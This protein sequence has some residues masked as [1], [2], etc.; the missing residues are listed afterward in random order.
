VGGEGA[1]FLRGLDEAERRRMWFPVV[2]VVVVVV[3]G[4]WADFCA[5]VVFRAAHD[6]AKAVRVWMGEMKKT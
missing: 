6:G 3:G 5:C 4:D 2:G 1:E